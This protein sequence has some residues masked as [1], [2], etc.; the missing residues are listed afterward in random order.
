[1]ECKVHP[2]TMMVLESYIFLSGLTLHLYKNK[3]VSSSF[4]SKSNFHTLFLT[5]SQ[6]IIWYLGNRV[7]LKHN[8]LSDFYGK[9]ISI[10]YF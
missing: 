10:F 7:P 9:M 4:L 1:M 5:F 3:I 8:A 6:S 2:S